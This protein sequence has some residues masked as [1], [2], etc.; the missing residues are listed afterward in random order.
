M[1]LKLTIQSGG[2]LR[3]F[4]IG[5]G[6]SLGKTQRIK[7]EDQLHS[8]NSLALAGSVRIAYLTEP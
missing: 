5:D 2:T 6:S 8:D 1:L 7:K 3:T 4:C